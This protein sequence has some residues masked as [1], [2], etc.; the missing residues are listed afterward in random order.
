MVCSSPIAVDVNS[1]TTITQKFM[2]PARN[3]AMCLWS[4]ISG[5]DEDD[6][7]ELHKEATPVFTYVSP[8]GETFPLHDISTRNVQNNTGKRNE[9]TKLP[10][11][12]AAS[13]FMRVAK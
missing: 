11:S 8:K 3:P 5:K 1:A 9:A 10:A 12:E 6:E 2:L 7:D 4:A 13:E